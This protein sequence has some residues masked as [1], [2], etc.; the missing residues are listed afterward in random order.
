MYSRIVG[1]GGQLL[2]ML[3]LGGSGGI[4]PRKF[5]KNR[6]SEIESEGISESNYLMLFL[7]IFQ[8]L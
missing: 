5:L 3:M 7:R 1:G 8:W 4:P 6:P 2:C